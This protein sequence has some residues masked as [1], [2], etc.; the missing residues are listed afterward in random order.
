[1]TQHAG[2][3]DTPPPATPDLPSLRR[4]LE[5]LFA[6]REAA[7]PLPGATR[8]YE[9][10]LP[11]DPEEPLE[12][13]AALE[14][15]RSQA[16][17]AQTIANQPSA[18]VASD[19]PD[20]A[21]DQAAATGAQRDIATGAYLPYWALL[22]P[23]GVALAEALLAAPEVARGKRTLELGC[24]LGMTATAA[25]DC[26]AALWVA[27]IFAE[28]LQFCHYNTLRNVGRAPQQLL[29]NWRSEAGRQACVAAGPFDLLL[30]ADV[31]YEEEDIQ[32]LLALAPRLL[33]PGG[34]FWLAEPGRRASQ[35][36]ALAALAD[37]GWRDEPTTYLRQWPDEQ[38]PS[39]VVVHRFTLPDQ[40][41]MAA[42]EDKFRDPRP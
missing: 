5:R 39:R 24:G 19:E 42:P 40:P 28:A 8:L 41:A 23:S 7:A 14:R 27:D 35:T 12:Q 36:F 25:L 4:G 30:G 6:V 3:R 31:L 37:R 33:A 26:G 2:Q 1:M 10:T 13:L 16:P 38:R 18:T 34:V 21:P 15:Q 29:V 20:P 22:W 17:S 9:M 32:P 11:A